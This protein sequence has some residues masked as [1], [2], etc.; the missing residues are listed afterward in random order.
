MKTRVLLCAAAIALAAA[1]ADADLAE[2]RKRAQLRVLVADSPP[3]FFSSQPDGP[4]GLEREILHGF[5]RLHAVDLAILRVSSRAALF[6][7]LARGEGDVAA[8][9]L[10]TADSPGVE[11]SAEI[12]PSRYVVVSRRPVPS[13]FTLAELKDQKVGIVKGASVAEAL[14]A[15]GV[16][17]ARLELFDAGGLLPALKAGKVA[18]GVMRV[19]EA[20]PAQRADADFQLGM[21]LGSRVSLAFAMRKEDAQL[22]SALSEYVRN[23]RRSAAWNRLVLA[24]FGDAAADIVKATR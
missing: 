24:Y 15:N 9:G 16:P 2:I 21:Y 3:Q 1:R 7:A 8:G 11:Y 17:E 10:C 6:A 23:I 14:A 20:I 4:P 12:L 18:V 22:R 5:A 13:V 19:E